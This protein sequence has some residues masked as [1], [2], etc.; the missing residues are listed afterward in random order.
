MRAA[1]APP[2]ERAAQRG[3]QA[4]AAE[5]AAAAGGR[6]AARAQR[7][8]APRSAGEGERSRQPGGLLFFVFFYVCVSM[9][10]LTSVVIVHIAKM[11]FKKH[12]REHVD[13]LNL[14]ERP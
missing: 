11:N 13:I 8:P 4:G 1:A 2:A 5:E 9:N 10:V 3:G 14:I 12:Y 6:P 7:H